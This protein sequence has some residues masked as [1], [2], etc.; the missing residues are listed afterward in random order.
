M[1]VVLSI[2]RG[3]VLPS[4]LLRKLGTQIGEAGS[5]CAFRELGR[6]ERTLFLLRFVSDPQTR[7]TI[8][9]ETT[10][11]EVLTTI[12]STG[13]PSAARSS[14][15][16]IRSSRRSSSNTPAWSPTRSCSPTS[17]TCT[18][19]SL[20]QLAAGAHRHAR[21]G[22]MS[23]PYTREHIR[24]FGQYRPGHGRPAS[25]SQSPAA[26]VRDGLVT[27]FYTYS[28]LPRLWCLK[29]I[30]GAV[31]RIAGARHPGDA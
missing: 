21:P 9:A 4:M 28:Q 15:A 23:R 14:K 25:A 2:R 19:A 12:F 22:Q 20:V 8:R 26:P 11:I 16:A 31:H 10:K 6:V 3:V 18:V 13:S 17:P 29:V 24:R 27:T 1:Q 7:R 5:D 30:A